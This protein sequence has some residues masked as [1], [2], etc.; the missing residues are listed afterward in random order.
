V[1]NSSRHAP[2]CRPPENTRGGLRLRHGAA[3]LPLLRSRFIHSL[4]V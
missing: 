2:S 1:K 4:G 3:C